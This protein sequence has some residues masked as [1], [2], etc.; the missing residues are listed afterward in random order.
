MRVTVSKRALVGAA[1]LASVAVV[2]ALVLLPPPPASAPAPAWAP[3]ITTARGVFHIH[4]TR[5]D[6]TGTIDDV[7]AAAA[8]AGLQFVIVTDHGDAT[9]VP[10]PPV[11]RS[12]VLCID[13]VEISTTGGHYAALG[14][15]RAPYPLA[16]EPRDVVDDVRRLGGFGIVTHP[17]SAKADLAWLGWEADVDGFEWLNGDSVWRDASLPRLLGAAWAYPLRAASSIASLYERP[18]AIARWDSLLKSG[19]VVG[20]AGADA[21]ARL[22]LRE[23]REPYVGRVFARAPS[24]EAVF[25]IASLRVGLEQPLA[26]NAARDAD[27]IVAG[28]RAGRVHA[29]VDAIAAPSFFE[30][31]AKSGGAAAI[32]GGTLPGTEPFVIR[33]RSNPP[34]GGWVVLF[35]DGAEVHRVKASELVYAGDRP[36]VYRAEVWLPAGRADGLVPWIVGNPIYIGERPRR[37][38]AEDPDMSGPVVRLEAA[39]RLWGVERDARSQAELERS[40]GGVGL[41]FT[42]TDAADVVPFAALDATTTI[43]PGSSGLAFRGRADRPMRL[44]VQIRVVT[45]GEGKRWQRS[46]YLDESDRDIVIPFAEMTAI[47][48]LASGPPDVANVKTILWVADTVNTTRGSSRRFLLDQVRFFAPR[49]PRP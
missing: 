19:R 22:G 31:T 28:I 30:F 26:R 5:S 7:A 33:A 11:Y 16:G 6:G 4:T 21:H 43:P 24:Y 48:A 45:A 37:T 23:G 10:D 35:R 15:G 2:A 1:V 36:G 39:D 18:K 25:E 38:A 34:V 14:L 40:A 47:G 12:G 41:R 9:R 32:E 44:S 17:L 42:L 3:S 49:A 27:A 20:L 13:A 29:V 46:V 8:E